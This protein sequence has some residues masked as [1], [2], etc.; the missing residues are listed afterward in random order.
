[1]S[2]SDTIRDMPA[3]RTP[4]P[5]NP[6]PR[7]IVGIAV[8]ELINGRGMTITSAGLASHNCARSTLHKIMR[9]EDVGSSP[10]Q[11]IAGTLGLPVNTFL[12]MLKRDVRAIKKLP[13]S[14]YDR[15]Y[16]LGLLDPS[17]DT[18]PEARAA[19]G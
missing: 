1:M 16:I 18:D 9:G 12:L 15:D 19:D 2:R 5:P 4:T 14:D 6:T 10:L 11:S 13:L 8:R 7:Q 3:K 17:G